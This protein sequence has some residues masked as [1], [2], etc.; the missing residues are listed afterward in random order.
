MST[1]SLSLPG[2]PTLVGSGK[3]V[4]QLKKLVADKGLWQI[5]F[6]FLLSDVQ[7]LLNS[8]PL[9]QLD[10]TDPEGDLFLTPGH[11]MLG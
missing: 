4:S 7:A 6:H 2:L 9:A 11:F 1:G 5:E 8:R 3:P 10:S